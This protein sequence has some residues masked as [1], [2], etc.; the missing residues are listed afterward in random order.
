MIKKPAHVACLLAALI[1]PLPATCDG[2]FVFENPA[3][4]DNPDYIHLEGITLDRETIRLVAGGSTSLTPTLNPAKAHDKRIEWTTSNAAV[5][6]VD[7][8]GLVSAIALGQ[9]VIE[10]LS[11]SNNEIRASCTVTVVDATSKE[12]T[13]FGF[14]GLA[15]DIPVVID[16]DNGTITVSLPS[17]TNL[18]NLVAT[19]TSSGAQVRIGDIIQVSGTTANDFSNPVIYTVV[20]DDG[21]TRTYTLTIQLTTLTSKEITGFGFTIGGSH[22]NGTINNTAGTILVTVPFA[23]NRNGLVPVIT[24]VGKSINPL[25]G[26]ARD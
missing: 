13:G 6:T 1:L 18:E 20:A 12:I 22:F 26:I 10:A 17:G 23:T 15:S 14:V 16:H 4:L 5:A 7:S 25:S 9:A 3:D 19:F 2:P 24:H 8:A 11:I 21:S